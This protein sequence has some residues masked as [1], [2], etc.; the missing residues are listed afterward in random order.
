[1]LGLH[2]VGRGYP[3]DPMG[4]GELTGGTARRARFAVFQETWVPYAHTI[5]ISPHPFVVQI[6]HELDKAGGLCYARVG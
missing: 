3:R 1:M 6:L 4:G 5:Q 2:N